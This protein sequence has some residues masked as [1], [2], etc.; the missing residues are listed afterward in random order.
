M[1]PSSA[2]LKL[3]CNSAHSTSYYLSAKNTIETRNK[4]EI[5]R[6]YN[7]CSEWREILQ[8]CVIMFKI[9][10]KEKTL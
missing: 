10:F 6:E 3:A 1:I 2:A 7:V 5:V 9:R 8:L 4:H